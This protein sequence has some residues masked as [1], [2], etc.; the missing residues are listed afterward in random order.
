MKRN[1]S[2]STSYVTIISESEMNILIPLCNVLHFNG[3]LKISSEIFPKRRIKCKKKKKKKKKKS[4]Y[5]VKYVILK[6]LNV[7]L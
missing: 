7:V 3:I 2:Q 6:I 5:L 4:A 1:Y